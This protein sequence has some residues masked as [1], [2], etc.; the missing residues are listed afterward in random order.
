MFKV[1]R[2]ISFAL[3]AHWCISTIFSKIKHDKPEPVRGILFDLKALGVY[4][5]KTLQQ[6]GIEALNKPL[7]LNHFLYTLYKLSSSFQQETQA[8][9]QPK[10]DLNIEI[11]KDLNIISAQ[12]TNLQCSIFNSIASNA[13]AGASKLT[14]EVNNKRFKY[15]IGI[16]D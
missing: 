11:M 15:Y 7:M 10:K 9:G 16:A 6:I 8:V 12:P 3:I 4:S 5:H 13:F 1:V 2:L 14:R